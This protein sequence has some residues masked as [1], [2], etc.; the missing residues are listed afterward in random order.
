M[1][2]QLGASTKDAQGHIVSVSF[3]VIVLISVWESMPSKQIPAL[4]LY[5]S[6]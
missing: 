2:N 6:T 3:L 1:S 4:A 5:G